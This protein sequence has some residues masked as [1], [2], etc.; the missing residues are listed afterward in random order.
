MEFGALKTSKTDDL[1]APLWKFVCDN[2]E[3]DFHIDPLFGERS[4]RP[5]G[6]GRLSDEINNY[7]ITLLVHNQRLL[8]ACRPKGDNMLTAEPPSTSTDI[9]RP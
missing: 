2:S 3:G 8:A 5:A 7:R 9:S 1:E 6:S 4:W